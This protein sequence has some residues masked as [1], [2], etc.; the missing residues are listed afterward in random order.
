RRTALDSGVTSHAGW[1]DVAL[2]VPLDQAFTYSVPVGMEPV[3]GGRVRVQWGNR[4]M[5]GVAVKLRTEAPAEIAA[6]QLKPIS[7]V[8]DGAPLLEDAM[9]KLVAW[10]A[11]YYQAPLGEVMR[12]ALPP[13]KGDPPRAQTGFALAPAPSARRRGRDG[14]GQPALPGIG[15]GDCDPAEARSDRSHRAG[16]RAASAGLGAARKGAGAEPASAGGTGNH[17][18]FRFSPGAAARRHRQRQDRGLHR[19]DRTDAR[20]RENRAA[21]G[22]RNWPHAGAFRGFSRCLSGM[23]AVLH[24]GLGASE[25]ARHWHRLRAGT[26]R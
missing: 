11:S 16:G 19:G 7:A 10:T 3:L 6:A 5:T 26:A 1:V 9:L 23:V 24:S 20:P 15:L 12:C 2:P 25:R 18:R 8:V 21:A 22:A 4:P 14:R 13:G 17:C